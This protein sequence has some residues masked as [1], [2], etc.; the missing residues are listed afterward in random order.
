MAR[1]YANASHYYTHFTDQGGAEYRWP[2]NGWREVPDDVAD[3]VCAAH[4]QKLV[5]LKPGEDRPAENKPVEPEPVAETVAEPPNKWFR[6][7][8][9][10]DK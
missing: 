8:V 1:V 5:R 7:V 3:I 6:S 2:A 9:K 4:P 10:K